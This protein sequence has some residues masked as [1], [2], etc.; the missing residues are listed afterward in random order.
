MDLNSLKDGFG[1]GRSLE[2]ELEGEIVGVEVTHL[3]C[4]EGESMGGCRRGGV[5]EEQRIA[6]EER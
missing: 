5:S 6:E 1:F 2:E 3:G 4:K